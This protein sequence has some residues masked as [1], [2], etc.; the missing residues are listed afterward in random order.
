MVL[1]GQDVGMDVG[2]DVGIKLIPVEDSQFEPLQ[3]PCVVV[4]VVAG[5][6]VEWSDAEI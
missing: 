3:E 5:Q 1:F 4:A 2:M 6:A